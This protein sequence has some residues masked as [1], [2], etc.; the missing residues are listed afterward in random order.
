MKHQLHYYGSHLLNHIAS[1]GTLPRYSL[2]TSVS[3][4]RFP[5]LGDDILVSIV[6]LTSPKSNPN[7]ELH[8]VRLNSTH[9]GDLLRPPDVT[10]GQKS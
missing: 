6:G 3:M 2:I 5:A 7:D 4:R 10:L 9:N 8:L 1:L